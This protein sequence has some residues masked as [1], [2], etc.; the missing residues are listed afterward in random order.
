MIEE[1]ENILNK[2]EGNSTPWGDKLTPTATKE[3]KTMLEELWRQ[4]YHK[5]CV[6]TYNN[7]E[8]DYS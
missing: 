3:L 7:P 1:I 5:G 8:A 2:F 6:D 4:A